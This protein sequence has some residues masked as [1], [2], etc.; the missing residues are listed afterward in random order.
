[1]VEY[2]ERDSTKIKEKSKVEDNLLGDMIS[3]KL[4]QNKAENQ[5]EMDKK[6]RPED[7]AK[8]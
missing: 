2:E 8:N 1:M 7:Y 4:E 5:R 3:D 6:Y